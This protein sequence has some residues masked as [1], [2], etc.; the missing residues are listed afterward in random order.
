MWTD[1]EERTDV[2]ETVP[3][4]RRTARP[5][6]ELDWP[7]PSG[8]LR[9]SK[10]EAEDSF[11]AIELFTLFA[12]RK[13]SL[14]RA[15]LGTAVLVGGLSFLLPAEYTATTSLL[16]P[17]AAGSSSAALLSQMSGLGSLGGLGAASLG[18]KSPIDQDIYLMKTQVVEDAVVHRFGLQQQFHTRLLSDARKRLSLIIQIQPDPKAGVIEL[19]ARDRDPVRAAELANGYVE[20]YRNLSSTLAVTEAAQRRLF[21][22]GQLETEKNKLAKAEEDLKRTE[23]TTGMVEMDSQ[24]RA[25]I[26][27]V[28]SLRAQIAAKEV[29]VSS[30]RTYAAD[31]NVDLMEAQQEL[32]SLRAQLTKLGGGANAG[33]DMLFSKAR[34]P[35]AGL[36]YVR[37]YREVKY[38]ETL[39]EMLARQNEMAKLDEAKEGA[40]IQVIEPAI[41]PDRRSAPTHFLYVLGGAFAGLFLAS[42]IVGLRAGFAGDGAAAKRAGAL[43]R[44][45]L[46]R[47]DS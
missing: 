33:S 3:L 32:A 17:Q 46:Q 8:T 26:Q 1:R 11:S 7:P 4:H 14:V 16:P 38:H 5:S 19:S 18:L 37:K 30:M 21:F 35:E 10:P 42:I 31:G 13:W 29:Q 22:E 40:I 28:G 43:R 34:L 20:E 25:L 36:E 44:A 23:Q 2:Q 27:S 41:P 6:P 39:F 45:L 24:A 9:E 15:T 12:R 47:S